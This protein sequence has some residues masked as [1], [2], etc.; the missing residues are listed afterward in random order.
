MATK[1]ISYGLRGTVPQGTEGLLV[2]DSPNL[3]VL[4]D[5]YTRLQNAVVHRNQ[6][7][8]VAGSASHREALPAASKTKAASVSSGKKEEA[9]SASETSSSKAASLVDSSAPE[10]DANP[11]KS[12]TSRV[13]CSNGGWSGPSPEQATS[14]PNAFLPKPPLTVTA[15]IR[16][17]WRGD[18]RDFLAWRASSKN[19]TESVEF[20]LSDSGNLAYGEF[21]AGGWHYVDAHPPIMLADDSFH[22]VAVVRD[23]WGYVFLYADGALVGQGVL[24]KHFPDGLSANASSS[25]RPEPWELKQQRQAEKQG[26]RGR[27]ESAMHM[28]W[29]G[30]VKSVR[31]YNGTLTGEHIEKVAGA[32]C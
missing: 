24:P 30:G 17:S 13:Y 31:L 19:G 25:R 14:F 29:R 27:D 10:T 23:N 21:G 26:F 5:G 9:T 11:S 8:E 16:T 22:S 1:D 6:V 12:D 32:P 28:V 20:Q 7:A 2:S 4:W 3:G 18:A 15:D